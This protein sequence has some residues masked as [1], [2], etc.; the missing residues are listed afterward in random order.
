MASSRKDIIGFLHSL[1]ACIPPSTK[2]ADDA[3]TARLNEALDSAQRTC[4]YA[5]NQQLPIDTFHPWQAKMGYSVETAF[6]RGLDVIEANP[7]DLT[8]A[9]PKY[10]TTFLE[11]CQTL[12]QLAAN[13]DDGKRVCVI[14]DADQKS[15]IALRVSLAMQLHP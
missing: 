8:S 12:A 13:V 3:L 6:A 1:G 14:Q 5:T 2:L 10:T 9:F 15:C 4:V 7:Q 11:L